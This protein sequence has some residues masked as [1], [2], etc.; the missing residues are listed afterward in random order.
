MAAE[1]S[2]ATD[3]GCE[4]GEHVLQKGPEK[5]KRL[6]MPTVERARLGGA[7]STGHVGAGGRPIGSSAQPKKKPS[8]HTEEGRAA[9][10]ARGWQL[11]GCGGCVVR[12]VDGT[13]VNVCGDWRGW[14]VP[15]GKNGDHSQHSS[16]ICGKRATVC[17]G[18]SKRHP[19]PC[20]CVAVLP[21]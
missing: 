14:F 20:A 5:G 3:P 7:N 1:R 15:G 18:C 17:L 4:K 19:E 13:T 11:R 10:A 2:N 21:D 12:E 9:G 8:V 6:S 16:A